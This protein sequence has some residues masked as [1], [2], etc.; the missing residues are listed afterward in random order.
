MPQEEGDISTGLLNINPRLGRGRK[1]RKTRRSRKGGM[2]AVSVQDAVIGKVYTF[3]DGRKTF[4]G[5]LL[6]KR[7][8]G[9]GINPSIVVEKP[10]GKGIIPTPKLWTSAKIYETG[11][12]IA[13]EKVKPSLE[14]K[15][16]DD[17]IGVVK[18]YVGSRRRNKKY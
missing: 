8:N 7:D 1:S 13:F 10:I 18:K 5:K 2:R 3:S 17:V 9:P 12:N 6:E 11:T 16:N 15:L 14:E 4:K